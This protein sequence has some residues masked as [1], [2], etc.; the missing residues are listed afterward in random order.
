MELELL[1]LSEGFGGAAFEH[2]AE[3]DDSFHLDEEL[4]GIGIIEPAVLCFAFEGLGAEGLEAGVGVLLEEEVFG[5]AGGEALLA[6]GGLELEILFALFGF[7]GEERFAGG[8]EAVT[9]AVG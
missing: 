9:E 3:F 5:G 8:G 6:E 7:G 1:E 4:L 2:C